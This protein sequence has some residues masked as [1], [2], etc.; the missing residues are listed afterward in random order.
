MLEPVNISKQAKLLTTNTKISYKQPKKN[1]D[2]AFE[3]ARNLSSH[4]ARSRTAAKDDANRE[5]IAL[6]K[7]K[8]REMAE[9]AG[10][11]SKEA[12]SKPVQVVPSRKNTQTQKNKDLLKPLAMSGPGLKTEK[13]KKQELQEK[14]Q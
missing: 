1:S 14:N 5:K 11:Q 10:H 9:A 8:D 7:A 2:F 12:K 6:A 3:Y 4:Q 13:M